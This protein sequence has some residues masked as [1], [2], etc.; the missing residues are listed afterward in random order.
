MAQRPT[1]ANAQRRP[2]REGQEVIPQPV[3]GRQGAGHSIKPFVDACTDVARELEA[4]LGERRVMSWVTWEPKSTIS[5]RSDLR[6]NKEG[7]PPVQR[8]FVW[9]IAGSA[10]LQWRIFVDHTA[11]ERHWSGAL[12]AKRFT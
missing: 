9:I 1:L 12:P 6:R 10:P 7:G 11:H 3:D 2:P 4:K 8:G 5:R